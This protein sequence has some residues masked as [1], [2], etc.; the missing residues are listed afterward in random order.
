MLFR[1]G[2]VPFAGNQIPA[3]RIDPIARAFLTRVPLPN[4]AGTV[5]NLRAVG[6][7]RADMDQFSIRVDHRLTPQDQLF[8]RF[9]V[10]DVSDEQPFGTSVLNETLVPGFGRDVTT[11]S[12]NV[13]VGYL[14][15]FGTTLFNELRVG[16]LRVGG[17]QFSQNRGVDFAGAAGL[18]GVTHDPRDVGFPQV[19]FAGLFNTVGDPTNFTTRRNDSVEIYE[20]VLMERDPHTIKFGGYL[21]HLEFRPESPD[22]ARGSFAFTGQ[23]TGNAFADFLL[24]YPTNAIAGTGRAEEDGRTTWTHFFV[25]DDWRVLPNL[26]LNLGLRTEVNQH[27]TD[28]RNRLSSI[29]L[30]YPGGRFVIASDE[31]GN[32]A[33]EAA[34]LLSLIPIPRV[35][36]Q[37]AG[38]NR[39][40]LRPGYKRFAPRAGFV[41]RATDDGATVVRGAFGDRKSTRLN[42]SHVSESRMPSSA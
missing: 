20:N 34:P 28:T 14:R 41:W 23:F 13:A 18:Q 4:G 30:N 10:Y 17:G 5:Q 1:S 32:I 40:L 2:C 39:S 6:K 22:N 38:W 15:P 9:T 31:N 29:D 36:S 26:T 42:S 16:F 24:G 37:Q 27:I 12:R 35:T 7:Q 19:S 3:A 33:P 8:G 25:Q 21:F 11:T